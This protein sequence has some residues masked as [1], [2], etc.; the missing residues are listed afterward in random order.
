MDALKQ[1][2]NDCH[3]SGSLQN[4]GN[5]NL[6]SQVTVL[7]WWS[8]VGGGDVAWLVVLATAVGFRR[9]V[10]L[11]FMADIVEVVSSDCNTSASISSLPSVASK[12][13]HD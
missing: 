12:N 1:S 4:W 2:Q 8:V 11:A 5:S 6:E 3:V 13:P 9:L 7:S 10:I